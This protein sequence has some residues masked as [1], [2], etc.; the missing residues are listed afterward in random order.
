MSSTEGEMCMSKTEYP[1]Y[2]TATVYYASSLYFIN[3]W[4]LNVKYYM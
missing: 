4:K 2:F 3:K 1:E